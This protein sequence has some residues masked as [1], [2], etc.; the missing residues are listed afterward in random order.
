MG[1]TVGRLWVATPEGCPNGMAGTARI[2]SHCYGFAEKNI[3]VK[4]IVFRS[5]ESVEIANKSQWINPRL[6][7]KYTVAPLI[8]PVFPIRCWNRLRGIWNMLMFLAF[9]RSAP[10]V[11]FLYGTPRVVSYLLKVICL[12]RK[13]VMIQERNEYPCL[14]QSTFQRF[15][16][17]L[18]Y[19]YA[20]SPFDGMIV[21]TKLIHT[22]F[23]K[24]KWPESHL[25]HI[26]MSVNMERFAAIPPSPDN[27]PYLFY[28]GVISVK[29]DGVDLLISAF[30]RVAMDFPRHQLILSGIGNDLEKMRELSEKYHL[31][32]RILFT[33]YIPSEKIPA[34]VCNA[35]MLIL[36]RP[37][38][39][40][41]E[42][43]FPT[44][45]G[46]YL[47]SGRPVITSTVGEIPDY[48]N[49][50]ESAYLVEPGDVDSLEKAIRDILNHPDVAGKIG[51]CG[52]ETAK[53]N[54]NAKP[55]SEN[56]LKW[57]NDNYKL[58]RL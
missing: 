22:W 17:L 25:V 48:L 30:A 49:D 45:L 23:R 53:R 42:A 12:S 35:E 21:M 7:I 33:G 55:L 56:I 13:I 54:F 52:R 41:A 26:P 44:K 2:M 27:N 34:Y 29:K 43:G 11:L 14:E 4:I 16:T 19:R 5:T 28:A 36:A 46:E 24:R 10:Q 37:R 9:S 32:K 39:K 8:S 31:S 58:K 18:Y 38:S 40:Q 47:A 51:E 1:N 57:L 20:F 15:Q 6:E 50:R 3:D